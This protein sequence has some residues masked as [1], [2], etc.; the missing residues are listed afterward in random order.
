VDFT[1]ANAQDIRN[2]VWGHGFPAPV[3]DGVFEVNEQ[4]LLQDNHL[5]LKLKSEHGW[6][7]EGIYFNQPTLLPNVTH[8]AYR[9][10]INE[11]RGNSTLQLIVEKDFPA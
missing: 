8:L 11:W 5:K 6:T 7:A 9:L 1:I 10:E 2:H 4:R 3:F